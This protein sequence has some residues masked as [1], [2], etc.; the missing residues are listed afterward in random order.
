M[1]GAGNLAKKNTVSDILVVG[2]FDQ[3]GVPLYSVVKDTDITKLNDSVQFVN[4]DSIDENLS[5]DADGS[6]MYIWALQCPYLPGILTYGV[7][8]PG[9]GNLDTFLILAWDELKYGGKLMI[10]YNK[11]GE[12]NVSKLQAFFDTFPV[13]KPN[14]NRII[15]ARV[16]D[17][18]NW[19]NA[20]SKKLM[21][22]ANLP[23]GFDGFP[24]WSYGLANRARRTPE[25]FIV[26][27]E[28][29]AA[30]AFKIVSDPGGAA[31]YDSLLILTKTD[32]RKNGGTRRRRLTLRKRID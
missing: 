2:S 18:S 13:N 1:H 32:R 8:R 12:L 5:L 26:S 20:T 30:A 29:A 19:K 21:K 31:T 17:F 22:T 6:K 27:V 25:K 3:E 11:T 10:P 7:D 4:W 15:R 14:W 16:R 23:V 9:I 28:K 24:I